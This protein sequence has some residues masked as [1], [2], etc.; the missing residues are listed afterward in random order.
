ML[1]QVL[2]FE[3]RLFQAKYE[4]LQTFQGFTLT[5]DP[6]RSTEVKQ[7]FAIRQRIYDFIFDFYRLHHLIP[8]ET[9]DFRL[10]RVWPWPESHLI[11]GQNKLCHL[12]V[13]SWLLFD[14]IDTISLSRTAFKILDFKVFRVWPSQWPLKITRGC[15]S[16]L[17]IFI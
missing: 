4:R 1:F 17:L 2:D 11:W 9:L 6:W 8:F 3:L 7:I 10:F 12:E 13:H 5:F 14:F 16:I 15:L